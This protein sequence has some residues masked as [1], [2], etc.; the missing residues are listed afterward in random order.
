MKVRVNE[1]VLEGS[2]V[3]NAYGKPYFSFKGIPYA[4]P[5]IGDL[6]FKAPKPKQPWTGVRQAKEHGPICFQYNVFSRPPVNTGEE[7]CLYLNVYTPYIQPQKYLPVLVF[8]H[9]G[10]FMSGS[11]NQDFYGP[12]FLIRHDVILVTINYRLEVLGFLCLDTEDIPGNAGLKDQVAA[13]RWVQNNIRNFGGDPDNVTIFGES[14]G[15]ASVSLHLVSPM[16][17]GLF[18]RA[19]MQS[20]T[21]VSSLVEPY[22]ARDR[23]LLLAKELGCNSKNDKEIYDFFKNQPVERLVNVQVPITYTEL[24]KLSPKVYFSIVSEKKF[25]DQEWFLE[26]NLLDLFR[27]G[28]HEGVEVINGYTEDE[29]VLLFMMGC[30]IDDVFNHANKFAE[31]FVPYDIANHISIDQQIELGKKVKKYY[32]KDASARK[33]D[34]LDNLLK[35]FGMN[36]FV[37]SSTAWQKICAKRNKNNIYLYEFTCKSER[38]VFARFEKGS[39]L[40]YDRRIPVAHAD[41][42]LYL[43]PGSSILPPVDMNSKTFQMIDQVTKLWTNFARYGN[44]TPDNSLGVKWQPYTLE[45]Q[46][47]LDIGEKLVPGVSPNE[48]EIN[49]WEDIY[50]EYYPQKLP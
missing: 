46:S 10:A 47:Y 39:E 7:D 19:I 43:F 45:N 8:I 25:S 9:G 28:I 38:N 20:G 21:M 32:L 24:A 40:I 41:D 34:N 14:A 44:P 50:R 3:E 30:D 15:S 49:F 36:L 42:L 13:L 27:N 17:K 37:Y 5:P 33:E 11:G 12:E 1:G 23:A 4:E 35:F 22:G 16:S 2:A 6:R 48:E 29:G 18:K 26:G 31:F